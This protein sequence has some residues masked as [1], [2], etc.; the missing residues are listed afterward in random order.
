MPLDT[1]I[2]ASVLSNFAP[3]MRDVINGLMK[4][5]D[6]KALVKRVANSDFSLQRP[7]N[8]MGLGKKVVSG[9]ELLVLLCYKT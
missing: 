7:E 8:R 5:L 1:V 4:E 9:K 6:R 2:I 3:L